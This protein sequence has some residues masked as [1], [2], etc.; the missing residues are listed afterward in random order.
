[1]RKM[2]Q[3]SLTKLSCFSVSVSL[4]CTVSFSHR[5]TERSA[6]R[7]SEVLP[8][9][10]KYILFELHFLLGDLDAKDGSDFTD[11]GD[12]FQCVRLTLL[13]RFLLAPN[14]CTNEEVY[15]IRTSFLTWQT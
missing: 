12:V 8:H 10:K 11:E 14:N 4:S 3:I 13:L 9:A 6:I 15:S 1:M 7:V 2:V 5:T